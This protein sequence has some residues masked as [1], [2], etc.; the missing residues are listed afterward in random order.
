MEE[1]K[2]NTAK[3]ENCVVVCVYA[4]STGAILYSPCFILSR[5]L[6]VCFDWHLDIDFSLS[7]GNLMTLLVMSSSTKRG[8]KK[9]K[10][11]SCVSF[12]S[13][14]SCCTTFADGL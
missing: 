9:R 14:F 1:K 12:Y 8:R 6:S 4:D 2:K 10:N 13:S 11:R 5:L 7:L 3:K